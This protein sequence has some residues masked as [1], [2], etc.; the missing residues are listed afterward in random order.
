LTTASQSRQLPALSR[1]AL[2]IDPA[3]SPQEVAEHY[4]QIRQEIM[5][6][7]HRDLSEKHLQLALFSG[8]AAT[9]TGHTKKH[10]TLPMIVYKLVGACCVSISKAIERSKL[11][12]EARKHGITILTRCYCQKL[13]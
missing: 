12:E 13:P 11:D 1:I 4:R 3:L 8:T 5:P 2:T 10:R 6:A 7:R 9:P